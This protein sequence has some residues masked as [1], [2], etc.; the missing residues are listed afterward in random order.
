MKTIRLI[1]LF[2][3]LA[4]LVSLTRAAERSSVQGILISASNESGETDRRLAPYEPTLRRILRF[5]SFRFLGDGT[6]TLAVA[7]PGHLSLGSGHELAVTTE[8][9]EGNSIHVRVRWSSGGR[10]LMNT[11]LVLRAG[12]PAVLGGPSTGNKG[13]VYAVILIGR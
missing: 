7:E 5:E 10:T 4:G 11:G 1:L 9:V 12:V 6:A 2:A 13:E 8:K 3:I